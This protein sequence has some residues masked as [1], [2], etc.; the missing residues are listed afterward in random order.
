MTGKLEVLNQ[1]HYQWSSCKSCGLCE[2]RKNVVF[3]YGNPDAK[4]LLVGEAPG[5]NEDESGTPFIGN[6][7]HLLDEYL[8]Q[9]SANETVI[10]MFANGCS[11]E[12]LRRELLSEYYYTNIVACR[13]PENRDP[14]P[15]EVEACRS[16]L[17]SI[18]YVVDPAL[19]IAVGGIATSALVGKKK[20]AITSARGELFDIEIQGHYTTYKKPVLAILHTSFLLRQNDFK[21]PGGYG[22]KTYH[23]LLRAHH[24]MDKYNL[25]EQGM[26]RP[27]D[28]T[29]K[30]IRCG[31]AH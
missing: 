3:G 21:Q 26:N 30:C 2:T 19:I 27:L 7:G 10:K 5:A 15:K 4:I 24:I 8:A 13:P 16:R 23:D 22:Q 18:I 1:V 25:L 17:M 9:V 14:T 20:I 11:P 29:G 31:K 6:A 12:E 28:K